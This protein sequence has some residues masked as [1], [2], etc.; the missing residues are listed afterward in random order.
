MMKNKE[1]IRELLPYASVL[2]AAVIVLIAAFIFIPDKNSP[3]ASHNPSG[4]ASS[5]SESDSS[6]SVDPSSK[7][8]DESSSESSEDPGPEDPTEPFSVDPLDVAFTKIRAERDVLGNL[9]GARANSALYTLSSQYPY[10]FN[11]KSAYTSQDTPYKNNKVRAA[12]WIREAMTSFGYPEKEYVY[13]Q[14]LDNTDYPA[15]SYAFRKTG[16]SKKRIVIGA[17]YDSAETS[18]TEDN[19]TGVALLLE[20]AERFAVIPTN[21][22][23]DFCFFDGEETLGMC[24]SYSYVS[25]VPDLENVLLYINLDCV[26]VGDSLFAYGGEW[27]NNILC[28]SFGYYMAM[29]IAKEFGIPLRTIPTLNEADF[30]PP[31]RLIASDHYYFNVWKIPYLYFEANAWVNNA[32]IEQY[33]NGRKAYMYNSTN[34][35]FLD[36]NG[37]IIHTYHDDFKALN[38]ILPHQSI[39]HLCVLSRLLTEMITQMSEKSPA[40]YECATYPKNPGSEYKDIA[41]IGDSRTVYMGTKR[42]DGFGLVP[43]T[44]IFGT[45]GGVLPDARK[46]ENALSEKEKATLS[47]VRE[48]AL[49]GKKKAVFWYG[50]NDVQVNPERDNVTV[51]LNNYK[52]IL[53]LYQSICPTSKIYIVSILT[54]SSKEKDYYAKQEEN[55]GAYNNALRILCNERGYIYMDI[56]SLYGGE[57]SFKAGDHI[58]FSKLWYENVFLPRMKE[59][60][61]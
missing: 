21:L 20:L 60:L 57:D 54:T 48:A 49:Q 56:T 42:E 25:Q 43:D 13:V 5:D 55:I 18:G 36:T 12:E 7:S 44:S 30:R 47:D 8:S 4:I 51:F 59:W 35:Y 28:R 15:Y 6:E 45:Y 19:G 37:Q 52:R 29:D 50:I 10:R 23:I 3:G 26:G 33:P 9:Y 22:S 11:G 1:K 58:H 53:D 16:V 31:T 41:F 46:S 17:H 2:C 61:Q 24:G 39:K 27:E 14:H 34:E 32:G 40:Q 38:A